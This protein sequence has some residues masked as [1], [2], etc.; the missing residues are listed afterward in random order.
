[1]ALLG[2]RFLDYGAAVSPEVSPAAACRPL[3]LANVYE[4]GRLQVVETCTT[5]AGI[6]DYVQHQ[7]D[8]DYH[9][10]LRVDPPYRGLLDF[11][12]IFGELVLEI[13]PADQPGCIPGQR[14]PAASDGNNLGVCT[15]ADLVP[16]EHGRHIAATGPH[17]LDTEHGWME[18]HPVWGWRQLDNSKS[19]LPVATIARHF[20]PNE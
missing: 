15:G 17:V 11:K 5:V 3:P 7:D 10:V 4:P 13:V 20:I 19:R 14:L 8:G 2:L 12:N 18:I 9:I 16:P 6:V 1:M